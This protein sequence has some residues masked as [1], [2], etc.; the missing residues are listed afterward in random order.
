[1]EYNPTDWYW[2]AANRQG[3]VYASKA[4]AWVDPVLDGG[5]QSF[6][7]AG[8]IATNIATDGELADVLT[9]SGMQGPPVLN[10]QPGNWGAATV[11]DVIAAVQAAGCKI[12]SAGNAALSAH[13]PM[14]G[15][16]WATM[17]Q[18]QIG[19]N[20]TGTLPGNTALPWA[21]YDKQVSFATPADFAAVY[22]GLS[23]Y[24]QGWK[25]W[26][27]HGGTMP[28]WG[29]SGSAAARD[30]DIS[31]SVKDLVSRVEALEATV[32]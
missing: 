7:G 21:A 8:G 31:A 25:T 6:T 26:A 4:M 32:K 2:L 5:Y 14:A 13:Y 18:V 19:I 30:F 9:K 22:E 23:A 20:A 1:M 17:A 15:E 11:L 28:G 12:T 27:Y 10:V 24:L 29:A 16:P 3:V